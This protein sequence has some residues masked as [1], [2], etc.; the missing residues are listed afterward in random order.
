MLLPNRPEKAGWAP[1]Q[2]QK[3]RE[4]VCE[5]REQSPY[6]A[7]RPAEERN[8]EQGHTIHREQVVLD[9]DAR[10]VVQ[11]ERRPDAQFRCGRACNVGDRIVNL[12]TVDQSMQANNNTR[13]APA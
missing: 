2:D 12:N 1:N 6:L 9:R 4:F 13:P 3:R 8:V 7:S 5:K 11:L 10:E